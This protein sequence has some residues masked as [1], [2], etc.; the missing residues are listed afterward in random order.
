MFM[1]K[2]YCDMYKWVIN[3][4]SPTQ[5]FFICFKNYKYFIIVME[6]INFKIVK[7]YQL[8]GMCAHGFLGLLKRKNEWINQGPIYLISI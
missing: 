7:L 4:L 1:R 8:D 3:P 2:K 5:F 6:I